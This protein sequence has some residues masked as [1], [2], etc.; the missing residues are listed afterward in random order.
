MA[1]K[2]ISRKGAVGSDAQQK[3]SRISKHQKAQKVVARR[4]VQKTNAGTE[5]K[6]KKEAES[7]A[8][9]KVDHPTRGADHKQQRQ[10][11]LDR[12]RQS[13]IDPEDHTPPSNKPRKK[14]KTS[15]ASPTDQS[16]ASSNTPRWARHIEKDAQTTN[17]TPPTPSPV[18]RHPSLDRPIETS[19]EAHKDGYRAMRYSYRLIHLIH[20]IQ[21]ENPGVGVFDG[22]VEHLNTVQNQLDR[23]IEQ[24]RRDYDAEVDQ[25][26]ISPIA[27][28]GEAWEEGC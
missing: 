6:G 22:V 13:I 28:D 7:P 26:R 10:Q 12:G 24:S 2:K 5:A 1:M 23:I 21:S 3:G 9:Q 19:P 18:T 4:K 25:D 8:D 15:A 17:Q 14:V 20:A 16:K 27:K 11:R